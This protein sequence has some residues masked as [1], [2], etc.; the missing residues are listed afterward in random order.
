MKWGVCL[1]AA[2]LA[3]VCFAQSPII[4]GV[5]GG[6][7][8]NDA[9]QIVGS[10]NVSAGSD[11]Y[12]VGPTLGIRLPFGLSIAGDA[13]YT[14]LSVGAKGSGS[15][16][17]GSSVSSFSGTTNVSA[18]ASSWEFPVLVRYTAKGELFSP[19]IGAG[20]S[21][22]HLSGFENVSSFLTGTSS[23]NSS[24]PSSNGVGFVIGGGL[25][26]HLGPIHVSPEIR[27]THW[28]SNQLSSAFSSILRTSGNEAQVLVGVTF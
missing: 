24:I 5:R 22:R 21:V 17:S 27:Y 14:G 11:N 25:Q 6:V 13:L 28:G 4:F 3:Q 9:V 20:V 12:I 8:F 7:P 23:S 2:V 1:L 15:V 16:L 19:F 10:Q 26:F 18:S